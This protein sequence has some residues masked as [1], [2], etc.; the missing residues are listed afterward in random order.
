MP[1]LAIKDNILLFAATGRWAKDLPGS[2]NEVLMLTYDIDANVWEFP[3][4]EEG[5]AAAN[6]PGGAAIDTD[7]YAYAN[8]K[9]DQVGSVFNEV[10]T[11]WGIG[12]WVYDTNTETTNYTYFADSATEMFMANKIAVMAGPPG[13]VAI[14]YHDDTAPNP[15]L[16][17]RVS[18]DYGVTWTLR[19]TVAP[20]VARKDFSL[21]IDQAT[22][23]IFLA[24]QVS[25]SN[26]MIERSIDNGVVW[27]TRY[28]SNFMIADMLR[29]KL[30][31]DTSK[32]FL[33]ASSET[34]GAIEHSANEGTSWSTITGEPAATTIA[35]AA[36]VNDDHS[37][38]TV[39]EAAGPMYNY[40]W[41]DVGGLYQWLTR[42]THGLAVGGGDASLAGYGGRFAYSNFNF[43]KEPDPFIIVLV[44]RDMGVTWDVRE[45]PLNHY[46]D[47][48][49]TDFKG[50]PLFCIT[51]VPYLNHIWTFEKGNW[52]E[53]C[54]FVKQKDKYVSVTKCSCVKCK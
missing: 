20:N 33:F 11:N 15:Q 48:E 51:D 29:I 2:G 38:I 23:Y 39:A 28:A 34:A 10:Y 13:V 41:D 9:A 35:S 4:Y 3:V 36:G 32:L 47:G 54:G 50:C 44:S 22:G 12:V 49:F 8:W 53:Q 21:V 26:V 17:V 18:L 14:A 6:A 16:L 24:H 19:K 46:E 25:T 5:Y 43:H 1:S 40:I 31:S 27:T 30:V 45:T 42:D 37:D 52:A 7:L